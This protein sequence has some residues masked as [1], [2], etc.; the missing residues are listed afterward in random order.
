MTE[1]NFELIHNTLKQANSILI[2]I[3]EVDGTEIL[4]SALALASLLK[5]EGKNVEILSSY[6]NLQKILTM[7]DLS[8]VTSVIQGSIESI[9]SIDT[10]Q[11]PIDSIKYDQTESQLRIYLSSPSHHFSP[12]MVMIQPAK[13][14]YDLVITLDT[15]NWTQLGNTF[16]SYPH[17]FLDTPSLAISSIPIPHP[18]SERTV[19]ADNYTNSAE[20]I[21]EYIRKYS[22]HSLN[23]KSIVNALLL[24]LILSNSK[25]LSLERTMLK[26]RELPND[27]NTIIQALDNNITD[28]HRLLIGRILAHLEF[29]DFEYKG[30]AN[31]YA[32]SKLFPHDFSKTNTTEKDIVIIYRE[33]FKYLPKNILGLNIILE[34]SK[35]SKVGYLIFPKLDMTSLFTKLEG[36]YIEGVLLYNYVSEL[37]IHKVGIEINNKIISILNY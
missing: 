23:E 1:Q 22:K 35:S 30:Q 8:C 6:V 25:V 14:N 13:Y 19:I 28:N 36:E 20:I 27:Y 33:L 10:T 15:K 21:F 7:L 18:Y 4:G 24:S 31:R 11:Y 2:P 9:I 17:I 5:S 16:L 32:C 37:D 34:S 26:L 12:D 29:I 3:P